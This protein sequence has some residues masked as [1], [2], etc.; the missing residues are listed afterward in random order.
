LTESLI[1][2]P[3]YLK[4]DL[5]IRGMKLS[6]DAL[7]S[8]EIGRALSLSKGTG[9]AL[10][11]DIV[12]PENVLVNIP[13]LECLAEKRPYS[14]INDGDR[15]FITDGAHR[16]EVWVAATPRYYE[17]TTT[18]GVPMAKIGRTYGGYL[19]ISPTPVCEFLTEDL[20][21]RY[22]DLESKK[23]RAWSV[24]EVLETVEAA[25]SE[26]VAEYICLNVGY[27]RSPDGGVALLE[28]YIK[29]IKDKYNVLVCVQAQPPEVDQWIDA[30]YAMGIDSI[31]YNLEAYDPEV[32]ARIAPG[33]MQMVGR[34][35]YF[36]ALRHAGKI[37]PPGA[38]VS[39]LIVGLE[40][41]E[42]TIKG[43]DMLT[44]IGVI[45]TLPIYRPALEG[46]DDVSTAIDAIAP[47]HLHLQKAL[48]R[49][50]LA[51]TWISHFNL[52]LNAVEG[53]FFGGEA[54]LKRRWQ[55]VFKSKRG[56]KLAVNISG[57]R[58]RLRVR[59]VEDK[60]SENQ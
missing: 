54:P 8:P 10:G 22:C 48:K 47:V 31:A 30:G 58:R 38:V 14:L 53:H 55:S 25:L 1:D 32:F 11:L 39:N 49:N 44:A 12:L 36:E 50:R 15:F 33:K 4:L 13:V 56:A 6:R 17:K 45:P 9:A 7:A 42:S 51:P 26:G 2:N 52:A 34:E 41:V 27:T 59:S 18:S 24:D 29:A 5:M 40:P 46:A 23:G 60:V 16:V 57:F 37:F 3:G 35:R 28:P 21:C 43:I 19:A 20:A